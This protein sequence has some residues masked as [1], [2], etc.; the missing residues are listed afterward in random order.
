L[1]AAPALDILSDHPFIVH[2][3]GPWASES[4]AEGESSWKT[5][6]K[7]AIERIVYRQGDRFIVLSQAF[8]DE[9]VRRYGVPSDHVR[10]VP[11]GVDAE[12]FAPDLPRRAARVH[13]DWPTDR[14]I[15]LSVRRLIRRV[16]LENL[17]TAMKSVHQQVPDALLMIAGTGPLQEMLEA[18][19]RTAN[20]AHSVRFLGYLPD[21]DLPLAYHAADVSI[22]PTRSLEGFGLIAVESL[23]AGT[24][25]LVT[26]VGGLPEVVSDLSED[27]ILPDGAP[28]TIAACLTDALSGALEL[29]SSQDCQ[30]Y[31]RERFDWR[32]IADQ[33]RKVYAEVT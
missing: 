33:V 4:L 1:Y 7:T 27:L 26:P 6:L 22:V 18:Q 10:I 5:R 32:V 8:R 21:A 16:G 9:L 15:I 28:A 17:V 31:A 24:P 12:R 11:G 19:V 2:F 25:V 30:A 20:L 29:P 3:H 14:P 13:L 23:A